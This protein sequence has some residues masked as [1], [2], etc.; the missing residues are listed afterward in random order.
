MTSGSR[1]RRRY[2][3]CYGDFY[4][5]L[6]VILT[7]ETKAEGNVDKTKC[8]YNQQLIDKYLRQAEYNVP[9]GSSYLNVNILLDGKATLVG[10]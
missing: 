6:L 5:I 2:R 1:S 9:P 7:W 3:P 10:R 4:L 8:P